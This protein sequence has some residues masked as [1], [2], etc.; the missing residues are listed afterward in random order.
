MVQSHAATKKKQEYLRLVG[1]RSLVFE[2]L[3]PEA[4]TGGISRM[5]MLFEGLAEDRSF[6]SRLYLIVI[7]SA[8]FNRSRLRCTH[9]CWLQRV[10]PAEDAP[11]PT[12]W[13]E[14][15]IFCNRSLV[16]TDP[17][18]GWAVVDCG[19]LYILAVRYIR[20]TLQPAMKMT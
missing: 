17:W 7:P 3:K 11:P 4:E 18:H 6:A 2:W 20:P 14:S 5:T 9:V 15:M 1:T 8:S 13:T 12:P 10:A 16:F 19:V